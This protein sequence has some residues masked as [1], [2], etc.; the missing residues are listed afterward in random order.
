VCHI[1]K[2]LKQK[3]PTLDKANK[4][5]KALEIGEQVF[6]NSLTI[7]QKTKEAMINYSNWTKETINADIQNKTLMSYGVKSLI[8]S[9]LTYWNES[10]G[11]D[12]EIFW[13]ELRKSDI[14]FERKEPLRYALNKNRFLNVHQGMDARKNWDIL[15]K[16]N[17]LQLQYT[18]TEIEKIQIILETDEKKR[19]DF[20]KDCLIKNRIPQRQ[21]LRFGDSCAYFANCGLFEKY[22][23]SGQVD[24][25][26]QIFRDYKSN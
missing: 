7:D 5:L 15:L 23:T 24:T 26:Y 2:N 1:K 3:N 12:T 6:A 25:L 4:L 19:F 21:Y 18:Q 20:L 11:I 8:D 14:D 10:V 16:S 22:F 13:T 17:F 9:T